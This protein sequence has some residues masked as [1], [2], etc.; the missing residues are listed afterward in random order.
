MEEAYYTV[1]KPDSYG[2][3][4]GLRRQTNT[5]LG[6]IYK[7]LSRQDAYTLH[8]DI[9]RRFPRR[10]TLAFGID[11]LWQAD[12]IDL[13]SISRA[14][15]G[16]RYILTCIDVF[17]KFA[18]AVPLKTKT[19]A[20]VTDAFSSMIK[21][22][23]A[24]Y[25]QTDKGTE[26][27]NATFQKLLKDNGIKH[28]T[29]E[30]DDIKCAIV[31]RWHRTILAKLYRYFTY[32]N[33][34]RY[35]DVLEDLVKSYNETYHSS[36]KT[37][38]FLVNVH[39]ESDIR[40]RLY[41]KNLN[42]RK[43]PKFQIGDT[44][45]ISGSRR[46]FAKGYRDKWTEEVFRIV[47]IYQT[48]PLTYGLTDYLGESIKGKFYAQELQRVVKDVFRIEKVLKTR[49]LGGKTQYYV[50]WLGY[51]DKFNSWTDHINA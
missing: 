41:S 9:R 7:F 33:T 24:Y 30:N 46:A 51:P 25:L 22:R 3:A 16:F 40:Q 5:N 36:I 10:K 39:N 44:V 35:I 23:K 50:K 31:E 27:L 11:D 19:A 2:S 45:R 20:A 42:T 8:R 43:Q 14:N 37:A 34:T 29:S 28:Y 13:S 17:S 1:S 15:D 47:K 6:S 32:R 49:R 18:Q 38:P 21:N 4:S 26:F 48:D 12:L